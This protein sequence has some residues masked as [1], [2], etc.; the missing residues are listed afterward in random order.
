MISQNLEV[1]AQ[2]QES[3]NTRSLSNYDFKSKAKVMSEVDEM[4]KNYDDNPV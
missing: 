2:K 1:I 3:S 4:L